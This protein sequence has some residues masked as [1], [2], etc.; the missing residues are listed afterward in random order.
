MVN[1]YDLLF[2]CYNPNELENYL[3]GLNK[4][5]LIVKGAAKMSKHLATV[6]KKESSFQFERLGY[7]IIDKYSDISKGQFVWNRTVTL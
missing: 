6:T 7:F 2:T 5:S 3:D 1:L 4:N